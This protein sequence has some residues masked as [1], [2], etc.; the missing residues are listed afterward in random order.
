MSATCHPQPLCAVA[1]SSERL[2]P[3]CKVIVGSLLQSPATLDIAHLY[4]AQ[5]HYR[6]PPREDPASR[7]NSSSR[8]D[9]QPLRAA[10]QLITFVDSQDPNSRSAIQRHTAHH[11]N[12]Q[13]QEARMRSLR[14]NR[15]RLLQWQRRPSVDTDT[16]SVT[17][18][19]GSTSS[20]S[21][22][23]APGLRAPLSAPGDLLAESRIARPETADSS[24]TR[25]RQM[26]SESQGTVAVS[27]LSDGDITNCKL[28]LFKDPLI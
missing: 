4:H 26:L 7:S 17:S 21:V 19:Q 15:P 3:R 28:P 13:R 10:T 20:A 1:A 18:P 24:P 5:K 22:S 23:P 2:L 12:A 6:M 27:A 9:Q 11:S 14:I 25:P 8:A 16:L